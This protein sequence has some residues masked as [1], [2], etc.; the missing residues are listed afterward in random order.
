[1]SDEQVSDPS[2]PDADPDLVISSVVAPS[3]APSPVTEMMIGGTIVELGPPI[4]WVS[5]LS[6]DADGAPD[7][8]ALPGS[9]LN[10]ADYIGN[11]HKRPKD[12]TSPYCGVVV[13]DDGKPVIQGVSD[14]C[15]GY[16]VSTT[17]LQDKNKNRN[18]PN[19]YVNSRK[20]PF[21]SIPADLE[22]MIM[23]GDFCWVEWN[24]HETPA[25]IADYGPKGKVG[26]GSIFLANALSINPSPKHGGTGKGVKVTIW[27]KSGIGWPLTLDKINTAVDQLRGAVPFPV[28]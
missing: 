10:G 12:L 28:S 14:P 13:G 7:A 5:G 21:I 8:Y 3:P 22:H 23:L 6:V 2:E 24:G 25:V 26:E 20:I 1:M 27:P 11:A 19:R 17:A 18:D 4:V 9:G 15:P 16:L